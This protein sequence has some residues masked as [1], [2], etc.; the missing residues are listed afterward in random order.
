MTQ[1]GSKQIMAYIPT[2]NEV[3]KASEKSSELH[4]LYW[5]HQSLFT[6]N[7]WLLL[8][9]LIIPW[10]IFYFLADRSKLH[11]LLH[12]GAFIGIVAICLDSIGNELCL[13]TYP[14]NL[15]FITPKALPFDLSVLPVIYM[16]MYQYASTKKKYVFTCL[17]VSFGLAFIGEP[18]TGWLHLYQEVQ[19]SHYHS[20]PIYFLIGIASKWLVDKVRS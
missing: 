15:I 14:N 4:L 7:W 16:M 8:A 12:V 2:L 9:L 3:V 19:W 11:H 10:I 20:F 18:L 17:A 5:Y 1:K 13:W 6:W